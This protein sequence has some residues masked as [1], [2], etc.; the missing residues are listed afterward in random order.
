MKAV[1]EVGGLVMLQR[2]SATASEST[3][4]R[5]AVGSFPLLAVTTA[6]GLLVVS[7]AGALSRG[8]V[9]SSPPLHF[10]GI[11]L[12]AVPIFYRLTSKDAS[13]RERVA[14]VCLLGLAL[15]AVKVIR[16]PFLFVIADEFLHAFNADQIAIHDRFFS[17]NPS[18][19]VSTYYPG[20][21]G[22]TA[23]LMDMT[24]MSSF[25]AG[26]TIVGA[27]RLVLCIGL[28]CLFARITGSAR[29]AG[30]GAALYA[31]NPNFVVLGA[32]Y[33]YQSLALPLLVV[34]LWALAE[35]DV[36]MSRW[37]RTWSV[38]ILL[39]TVAV[40]V[41]HHVTSFGLAI[42]VAALAISYVVVGR[43][44]ARP[45]P[46]PFALLTFGLVLAWL[47]VVSSLALNYLGEIFGTAV[48][49]AIDTITGAA[50][51]RLPFESSDNEIA[52]TERTRT[53]GFLR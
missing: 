46:L 3:R 39:L 33:S 32:Q 49:V 51:F 18:L 37:L 2:D 25:A 53:N 7:L 1:P 41:T 47:I 38:P 9:L 10:A 44:W 50:Q 15:Y 4:S 14:L 13:D 24:G 35:R 27:A 19:P 8:T 21:E 20:L 28:F 6:L 16:G 42:V 31:A 43:G 48:D 5:I 30:I 40:V 23:A 52:M 34:I 12:I 36:A 11:L 29:T 26:T 17:P 45:N 22:A